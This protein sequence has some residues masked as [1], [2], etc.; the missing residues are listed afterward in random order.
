MLLGSKLNMKTKREH[1]KSNA[2]VAQRRH[3]DCR[4]ARPNRFAVVIRVYTKTKNNKSHKNHE[5]HPHPYTHDNP[6]HI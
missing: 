6:S 1:R 2:N 5:D 3:I 4:F